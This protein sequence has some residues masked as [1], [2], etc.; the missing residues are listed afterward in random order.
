MNK[1]RI[2][3]V[4]LAFLTAFSATSCVEYKG[5]ESSSSASSVFDGEI[6][7]ANDGY[8]SVRLSY[9]NEPFTQTSGMHAYWS[10][11]SS[12][13]AA[14]FENGVAKIAGLDGDYTVTIDGLP[15]ILF[16][17]P[18][19]HRASNDEQ[20]IT[21]DLYTVTETDPKQKGTNEYTDSIKVSEP[22]L[23]QTTIEERL[24]KIFYEFTP[25]VSGTYTIETI[26]S[27]QENKVNP[28][29][30]VYTGTRVAK[31]FAY[32]LDD[33]GES[34]VYTRNP[35]YQVSVAKGN[36]GMAYTFSVTAEQRDGIYPTDVYFL[37]RYEGTYNPP[38]LDKS[39]IVPDQNALISRGTITDAWIKEHDNLA[40]LGELQYPEIKI[41]ETATDRR[42]DSDLFG[43]SSNEGEDFY[44]MYNEST[45]KYDG[46][47][48][49]AQITKSHRFFA[50]N[51]GASVSFVNVEAT[52]GTGVLSLSNGKENYKLFIEGGAACVAQ[53]VVGMENCGDL[54]GLSDMVNNSNG[55][56]P[57]TEE[58]RSF[59]QK[60]AEKERYFSDGQGWAETTAKS[61]LGYNIYAAEKDMWLFA[62]CYYS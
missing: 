14:D 45:G 7:E 43:L 5:N 10:D 60:F 55:L 12:I 11:G 39:I 44:R 18:N 1:K 33:G 62:C 38:A 6:D 20:D 49:Y 30:D 53:N 46:A 9:K 25:R 61:D 24:H 42:F 23:Y 59:L 34:G 13:H 41:S 28:R 52:S 47:V 36:V 4:L 37:I 40:S 32:T 26:M 21:I 48:L 57:V 51:Q 50:A 27:T 16:Y 58:L 29:F 17:D 56:Y 19:S 15:I 31:Y 22:G 54:K 8:F 2:I 3:G 35:R